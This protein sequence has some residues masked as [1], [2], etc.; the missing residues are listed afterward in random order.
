MPTLRPLLE[1][2]DRLVDH[3]LLLDAQSTLP[4]GLGEP[5]QPSD[6]GR[7][8]APHPESKDVAE[9]GL[10]AYRDAL[11]VEPTDLVAKAVGVRV[12]WRD[13]EGWSEGGEP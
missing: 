4:H 5:C 6:V 8:E 9:Q 12:S 11:P 13:G 1:I 2:P 7:F 10:A 3:D